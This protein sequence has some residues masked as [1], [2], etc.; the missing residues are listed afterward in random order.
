MSA[1]AQS[2]SSTPESLGTTVLF[3]NAGGSYVSS[4]Y[5]SFDLFKEATS[6]DEVA[7]YPEVTIHFEAGAWGTGGNEPMVFAYVRSAF[8]TVGEA[9]YLRPPRSSVV[10]YSR[11]P[12]TRDVDQHCE[13]INPDPDECYHFKIAGAVVERPYRLVNMSGMMHTRDHSAR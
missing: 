2:A 4:S 3:P 13:C 10:G 7:T 6:T 5:G 8:A 11:V 9:N 1:L 12:C